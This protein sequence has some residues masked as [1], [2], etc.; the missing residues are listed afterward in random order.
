M[1]NRSEQHQAELYIQSKAMIDLD[2]EGLEKMRSV[3]DQTL[4]FV[5]ECEDKKTHGL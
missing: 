5:E 1:N 4:H 2:A 3:Y